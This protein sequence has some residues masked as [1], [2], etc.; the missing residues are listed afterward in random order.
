M[1]DDQLAIPKHNPAHRPPRRKRIA[2]QYKVLRPEVRA[3]TYTRDGGRCRCCWKYL[4]LNTDNPFML[5]HIHETEKPRAVAA[6]DVSLRSTVTLCYE[7]HIE[8][9]EKNR[10]KIDY[11][12]DERRCNARL[13]FTGT[14]RSGAVLN[15]L[16]SDPAIPFDRF[17]ACRAEGNAVR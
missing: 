8:N 17:R 10:V 7:C 11:D 6:V 3:D 4:H 13:Y 9:V 1:A 5:A 12:S 14:M 2:A 15:R 16:A